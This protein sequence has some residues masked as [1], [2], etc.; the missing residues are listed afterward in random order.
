MGPINTRFKAES[1]GNYTASSNTET[2]EEL[3]NRLDEALL[4]L[5]AYRENNEGLLDEEALRKLDWFESSMKAEVALIDAHES[6]ITNN[7]TTSDLPEAE[8][9]PG[10]NVG[11]G[12]ILEIRNDPGDENLCVPPESY[13][14]TVYAESLTD[15][16]ALSLQDEDIQRLDV[17][18]AGRDL[19]FTLT[20]T[21]GYKES[22]VLK[23]GAISTTAIGVD[24]SRITTHG[25]I[26]DA[27][28][29][30]RR[31][32]DGTVSGISFTG[33]DQSDTILCGA[34]DDRVMG[35][36][37]DDII[38]GGAGSDH[39]W[40]GAGND[41]IRGGLGA[42]QLHGD[43]GLDEC[44][45]SD[46]S[47][48]LDPDTLDSFSTTINDTSYVP[49]T[50]EWL[51]TEGWN[52]ERDEENGEIVLRPDGTG[53]GMID[54]DMQDMPF[55]CTMA[56]ATRDPVNDSLVITFAG[57]NEDNEP[58]TVKVRILNFFTSTIGVP[59]AESVVTLNLHGTNSGDVIDFGEIKLDGSQNINIDDT[60]GNDLIIGFE[61]QLI[62]DGIKL[63]DPFTSTAT[64]GQLTDYNNSGIFAH[65]GEL[66]EGY[67]SEVDEERH[68]IVVHAADGADLAE[69]VTL[70]VPDES[71]DKGYIT[72]GEDGLT[73]AILV[74]DDG[75]TV[76]IRF[77]GTETAPLNQS[78]INIWTEKPPAGTDSAE[79]RMPSL[80]LIP[81]TF[82]DN[83][84]TITSGEGDDVIFDN[85]ANIISDSDDYVIRDERPGR[86]PSR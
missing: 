14:G 53:G 20:Y 11:E 60:G 76:V 8:L 49:E 34:G 5:Q 51:E 52:I 83:M 25:I 35:L 46:S 74:G 39:I 15:Q 59:S 62:S 69:I 21:D 56:Q 64:N 48:N 54:I 79:T 47:M 50:D 29:S 86:A 72:V 12:G 37:G 57:V 36:A 31:T 68:Q 85:G 78:N 24:A 33:T 82:S 67:T 80:Q 58:I 77:E 70:V 2:M 6:G 27:T 4:E 65:E 16:I 84:Y 10:W 23:N 1:T 22:Y 61:A 32:T 18:T 7:E 63:D 75:E 81:I 13:V 17:T 66:D 28:H 41:R 19:V 55:D 45:T 9:T 42:D 3:H 26:I 40:G 38:D 43:S 73:Y 44:Y 30:Y 71:Y